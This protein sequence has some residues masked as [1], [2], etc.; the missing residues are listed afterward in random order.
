MKTDFEKG[1]QEVMEDIQGSIYRHLQF[2]N[3]IQDR[4]DLSYSIDFRKGIEYAYGLILSRLSEIGK[5]TITS[6]TL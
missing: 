3:I 4:S 2:L 5:E 6:I 1:R